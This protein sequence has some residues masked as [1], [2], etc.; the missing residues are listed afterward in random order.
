[1]PNRA[2]IP[3]QEGLRERKKRLTRQAISDVATQL[4]IERGFDNVTLAEIA[5]A[6]GVSKMTVSNYFARKED[7]FFDRQDEARELVRAALATRPH[8]ETPVEALRRLARR[9]LDEEHPFA[10]FTPGTAHFWRTVKQSE[11]LR[12]WGRELFDGLEKD[13]GE[14]LAESAGAAP[15]EPR[16]RMI[17]AMILAAWRVAYAEASRRRRPTTAPR[18]TFLALIEQAFAGI[19]AAAKDTPYV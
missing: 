13:L 16:A 6:V 1:M 19:R 18:T 2:Q 11:T 12:A 5:Q 7:L 17:A 10:K 9:L 8:G 4:F 3:Q 14:M 15:G